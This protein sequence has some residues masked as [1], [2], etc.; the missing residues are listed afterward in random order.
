MHILFRFGRI[1]LIGPMDTVRTAVK[2]FPG[3]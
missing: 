3:Y 2:L 1:R